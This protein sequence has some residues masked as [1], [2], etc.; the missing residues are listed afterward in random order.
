[1]KRNDI[2]SGNI[3]KVILVL[4]IL[5]FSIIFV[6]NF[7]CVYENINI[8]AINDKNSQSNAPDIYLS[9]FYVK[10]E[11]YD[12]KAADGT[13]MIWN[14]YL[15][16]RS[17]NSNSRP[18][19]LTDSVVVNIPVGRNRTVEFGAG[20]NAGIAELTVDGT[21]HSIDTYASVN[22]N[23]QY[24][25]QDSSK[26]LLIKNV[27]LKIVL[28]L[29]ISTFSFACIRM[30]AYIVDNDKKRGLHKIRWAVYALVAIFATV[31]M[32][33]QA[34]VQSFWYD[35][36]AQIAYVNDG[37]KE[38]LI[39]CL[40]FDEVTPPLFSVM[41]SIWYKIAPYGEHWL[42]LICI[43]P[44][45]LSIFLI[46]YLADRLRG[47]E[48][49]ILTEFLFGFC[50][51]IWYTAAFELRSYA[52]PLLFLIVSLILLLVAEGNKKNI[53]F[54]SISMCCLVMSH[55]FAMI[56]F[57]WLFFYVLIMYREKRCKKETLWAFV[58]PTVCIVGWFGSVFAFWN[59]YGKGIVQLGW[60]EIPNWFSVCNLFSY[61]SG[62]QTWLLIIIAL[63]LMLPLQIMKNQR[64]VKDELIIFAVFNIIATIII[65]YVYSRYVNIGSYTW[66]SMWVPRYFSFLFPYFALLEAYVIV[67]IIEKLHIVIELSSR[68]VIYALAMF[69]V[70]CCSNYIANSIKSYS[71][72]FREAAAYLYSQDDIFL[73]STLVLQGGYRYAVEGMREYYLEMQGQRECI[74]YASFEDLNVD[75]MLKYQTIYV[76][77][78]NGDTP[79][80]IEQQVFSKFEQIYN[81][82]GLRI[83]KYEKK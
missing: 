53:F 82:T 36:M 7:N 29:L 42:L 57:V 18:Q 62:Y 9:G 6:C 59:I 64:T 63:S 73:E 24:S 15:C 60:Q 54:L 80:D 20:V 55:Y 50:P 49:A 26:S 48:Y 37:I 10:G 68:I 31:L 69:M 78:E 52:F 35:E 27:I 56:A 76:V 33:S 81:N 43:I 66:R 30:G 19:V 65:V 40:A 25:I 5:A 58:P 28:F 75:E 16:W 83:R 47:Y 61:F 4:L 71:E 72:P 74:N 34:D 41:L 22:G 17:E 51:S 2:T 21:K 67:E 8:R 14:G 46:A 13:W 11:F 32:I 38:A 45:G 23:I 70:I 3:K 77:Y 12:A 39:H 44:V 79:Y 1:M